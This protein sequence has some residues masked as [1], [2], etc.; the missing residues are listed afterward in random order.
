MYA[1]RSIQSTEGKPDT[2]KYVYLIPP[3]SGIEDKIKF[4]SGDFV[5][6]WYDCLKYLIDNQWGVCDSSAVN[7]FIMDGAPYDSAYLHDAGDNDWQLTY[8]YITDGIELFV[9]K[10]E[11]LTWQEMKDKYGE[12]K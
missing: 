6:D 1:T 7:H 9:N 10:G 12:K 11:R 8:E 3:A 4:D 5:Q 2:Y